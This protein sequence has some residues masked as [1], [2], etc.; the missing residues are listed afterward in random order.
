MAPAPLTMALLTVVAGREAAGMPVYVLTLHAINPFAAHVALPLYALDERIA[1][2]HLLDLVD[3]L[4]LARTDPRCVVGMMVPTRLFHPPALSALD[5]LVGAFSA[6]HA[7]RHLS[8]PYR[9]IP[10]PLRPGRRGAA[11]RA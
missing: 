3:A 1:E 8:C 5:D 9:H 11:L 4:V 7:R 2:T 6:L 10:A